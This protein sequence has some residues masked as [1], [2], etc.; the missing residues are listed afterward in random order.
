MSSTRPNSANWVGQ[1]CEA[2]YQK[3]YRDGVEAMTRD[4]QDL[5]DDCAPYFHDLFKHY[6]EWD[7]HGHQTP[8]AHTTI[9]SVT[10]P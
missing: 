9:A 2:E 6:S 8:R 4:I 1:L 5:M 10:L 3:G 7:Q